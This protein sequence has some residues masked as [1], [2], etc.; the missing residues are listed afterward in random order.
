MFEKSQYEKT[1]SH[2]IVHARKQRDDSAQ[3]EALLYF[4][5]AIG[6]LFI[7]L[8]INGTSDYDM[9]RTSNKKNNEERD[10]D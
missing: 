8:V 6:G 10:N 9:D 2:R 5:F 4:M 7:M 3:Q 1:Q